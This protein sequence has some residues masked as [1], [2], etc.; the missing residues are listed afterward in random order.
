MG[1]D[2]IAMYIVGTFIA[3]FLF[4]VFIPNKKSNN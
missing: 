1:I 4:I 3:Y 2:Y